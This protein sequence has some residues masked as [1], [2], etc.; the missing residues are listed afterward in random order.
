MIESHGKY[1]PLR[2]GHIQRKIIFYW[3][4]GNDC[5]RFRSTFSREGPERRAASSFRTQSG[6]VFRSIQPCCRF[7]DLLL[8]KPE[9][10]S[11][12]PYTSISPPRPHPVKTQDRTAR[13]LSDPALII[14]NF[15]S[16]YTARRASAVSARKS[17]PRGRPP[18]LPP[19]P[20]P[21]WPPS[22]GRTARR[23]HR[24]SRQR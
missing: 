8:D 17:T 19:G 9:T 2:S 20:G 10:G 21:R 3:C 14:M 4:S 7:S 18:A 23:K 13:G 22:A 24:C 1:L 16:P 12:L 5:G 6:T 15:F 11:S